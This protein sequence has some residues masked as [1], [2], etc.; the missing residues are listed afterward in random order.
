MLKLQQERHDVA[1]LFVLYI[2][3]PISESGFV[4]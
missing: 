3:I 2:H 4:L 1:A